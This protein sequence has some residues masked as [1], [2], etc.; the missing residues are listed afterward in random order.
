MLFDKKIK[1]SMEQIEH[2]KEDAENREREIFM[3]RKENEEKIDKIAN[4][5]NEEIDKLKIE[6]T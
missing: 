6:N 5:L 4:D 3:L 2:L 1:E